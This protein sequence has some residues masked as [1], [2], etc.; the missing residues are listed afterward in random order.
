MA[1]N[2]DRLGDDSHGLLGA[3]PLAIYTCED[4]IRDCRA[5]KPEG[6]SYFVTQYVPVVR[7]L[8]EHYYPE[9]AGDA[10]L[11]ERVLQ[12]LG[13]PGLPLFVASGP[14]SEREFVAELRQFVL[15]AIEDDRAS[16]TPEL[17]I[18]IET[19]SAALDSLSTLEKQVAWLEAM[20]HDAERTA[21]IVAM[22]ATTV[23]KIRDR[24]AE[25]LRS[26]LSAWQA[27]MIAANGPLLRHEAVRLAKDDC[28]SARTWLDWLDGR[29]TWH[30]REEAEHRLAACWHCIDHFC[31]LREA[32]SL[33]RET[34]PLTA[35]DAEPFL[36]AFGIAGPKRPFWKRFG[37]TA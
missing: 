20:R 9:R 18:D 31:R 8:I 34:K 30:Q 2:R 12:T 15:A 7:R 13:K 26:Q 14:L 28:P 3:Q 22:H 33:L 21:H 32:Q 16:D 5:G 25:L 11:S 29:I 6:W 27:E 1:Q 35:I 36:K 19:L 4:M 23:D 24:A 10:G 37:S 17:S